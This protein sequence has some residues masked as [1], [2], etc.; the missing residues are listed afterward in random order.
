MKGIDIHL[1]TSIGKKLNVV[2]NTLT[3]LAGD[4]ASKDETQFKH[5]E[6]LINVTFC[7][8]YFFIVFFFTVFQFNCFFTVFQVNYFLLYYFFIVLLILISSY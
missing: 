1:D 7:F 2:W 5:V 8:F 3:S 4:V 6:E